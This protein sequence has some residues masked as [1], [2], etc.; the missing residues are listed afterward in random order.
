MAI[1]DDAAKKYFY[2]ARRLVLISFF[3]EK[4]KQLSL[5]LE[6]TKVESELNEL[7]VQIDD[8]TKY[9]KSIKQGKREV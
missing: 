9:I 5:Q 6:S 2:D 4:R 1:G 3:E 7:I 8:I